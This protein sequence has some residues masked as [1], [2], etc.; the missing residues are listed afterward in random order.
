VVRARADSAARQHRGEARRARPG[1]SCA[2]SPGCA[3]RPRS[4]ARAR[5]ARVTRVAPSRARARRRC[6]GRRGGRRRSGRRSRARLDAHP[7]QRVTSRSSRPGAGPRRSNDAGPGGKTCAWRATR[8]SRARRNAAA[9]SEWSRGGLG[10]VVDRERVRSRAAPRRAAP[11]CVAPVA[12]PRRQT[13]L[14]RSSAGCRWSGRGGRRPPPR[15]WKRL[16]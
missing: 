7:R 6:A 9:P 2:P 8:A 14:S 4:R 15:R 13:V 16:A 12:W 1:G 3:R 5:P 11:P 10:V